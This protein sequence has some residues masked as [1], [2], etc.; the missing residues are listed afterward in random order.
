VRTGIGTA[1]VLTLVPDRHG[2]APTT[3]AGD[4]GF[5][6]KPED[7][8]GLTAI[9]A[10]YYDPTTGRFI[11]VDPVMDL[12]DPQQWNAYIYA[13]GNPLTWSDPTGLWP[14]WLDNAA[15]AVGG[16]AVAAAETCFVLGSGPTSS[17]PST[18]TQ[19]PPTLAHG[20]SVSC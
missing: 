8:T 11:S 2:T 13:N 3:W 9:G 1:N 19:G 4:H 17:L 15:S 16:V 6:D 12:T 20:A 18:K 5:L 7:T 14:D 10:R